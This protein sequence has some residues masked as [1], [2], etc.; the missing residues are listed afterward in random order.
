[1]SSVASGDKVLVTGAT[2][3]LGSHLA[4]RLAAQ[5]TTVRALVRPGSR[6]DFLDALGVEIVRGDLTDPAA[7]TAAVAGVARV[8]HCAAKVGDWGRWREFQTGCIDATR[9]LAQAAAREGIDR[10]I[11]ISSTSAYGHPAE[12]RPPSMSRPLWGRTS[13]SST[14][15]RAARSIASACS[16]K[17]PTPGCL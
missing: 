17:W 11:H 5:G 2:G 13:G 12:V 8:F 10:F 9:I 4:E 7:C 16:G 6:T 14:I 3:L 15:T 1:M